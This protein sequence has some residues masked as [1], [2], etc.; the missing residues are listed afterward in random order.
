MFTSVSTSRSNSSSNWSSI[1]LSFI[2][3]SDPLALCEENRFSYFLRFA[4]FIMALVSFFS[5]SLLIST[6]CAISTFSWASSDSKEF[7][8]LIKVLSKSSFYL[9]NSL[10]F[11]IWINDISP[12]SYFSVS[13]FSFC[14]FNTT[15]SK[16]I[17]WSL[18]F[19]LCSSSWIFAIRSVGFKDF[20]I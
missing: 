5:T 3:L 2:S 14:Y 7:V 6:F 11:S 15:A 4:E 9:Y 18:D 1:K 16:F 12:L 10:F 13:S 17:R 19:K 20:T 8:L